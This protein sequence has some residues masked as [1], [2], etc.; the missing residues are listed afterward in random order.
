MP[1]ASVQIVGCRVLCSSSGRKGLLYQ[2]QLSGILE[3]FAFDSQSLLTP[4]C[5]SSL[6]R[7]FEPLFPES[8][9]EVTGFPG[10]R[11]AV[12]RAVTKLLL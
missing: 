8:C 11:Q 2:G 5:V 6:G 4:M 9:V 12:G 7:W 1:G 3:F 10:A